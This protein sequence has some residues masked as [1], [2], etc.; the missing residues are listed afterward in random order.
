MAGDQSQNKVELFLESAHGA[1]T[2][3][4]STQG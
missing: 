3:K 2:L 1:E 4:I